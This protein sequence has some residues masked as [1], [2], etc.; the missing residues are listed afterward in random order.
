MV[1][2]SRERGPEKYS[3]QILFENLK[4]ALFYSASGKSCLM[5]KKHFVICKISSLVE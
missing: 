5:K 3:Q 1:E 4:S 2:G